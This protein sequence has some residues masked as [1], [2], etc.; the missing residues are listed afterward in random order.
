[1]L[2]VCIVAVMWLLCVFI[3]CPGQLASM[4]VYSCAVSRPVVNAQACLPVCPAGC[5]TLAAV[6][7]Q[8]C[9]DPLQEKG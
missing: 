5:L 1:M 9:I 3:L 2:K 7:L 4:C 6:L 8:A